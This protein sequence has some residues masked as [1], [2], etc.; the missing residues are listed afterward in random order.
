MEYQQILEQITD[1]VSIYGLKII[2]SIFIFV[3]GKWIASFVSKMLKRVLERSTVEKTLITFL[4]NITYYGL[5]IIVIIAALSNLGIQMASFIA[6]LGAAGIA[7]G[8]ALQGSL[9]NFAAGVLLIIFKPF[10][11]D[12]Y[13]EA[14]GAEGVVEEIQIFK[15]V[16][17]S[18]D[19]KK[20]IL[21]NSKVM[22]D[23]IIN[24]TAKKT[25]RLDLT[26]GIGYDD[27]IRK[28]RSV[29]M[30]IL[31]GDDRVLS[32]PAPS[33]VVKELGDNSVNLGVRPYVDYENYYKLK[34]DLTEKIK[35]RFDE[36]GISFPYPQRDVH[37]F[38]A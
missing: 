14:G 1:V 32:D 3:V 38:Q 18:F 31:S 10:R 29:L 8:F 13:I 23:A 2:G 22:N 35:L 7:V 20:I 17:R 26:V 34:F 9:S 33:V 4:K 19:N 36:E 24:H 6:I 30:E 37:L 28:A 25:R 16:L 15:T 27:D 11:V 5:F 21:P 12:D